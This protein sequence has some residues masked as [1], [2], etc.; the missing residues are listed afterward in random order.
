MRQA[1]EPY[2]A[3]LPRRDLMN[4]SGGRSNISSPP[5]TSLQS[6]IRHPRYR[7]FDPARLIVFVRVNRSN[8]LFGSFGGS[9]TR[10]GS[11]F[12]RFYA[13]EIPMRGISGVLQKVALGS[14][15]ALT[16][17]HSKGTRFFQ[18]HSP[19][20]PVVRRPEAD[21]TAAMFSLVLSD[22]EAEAD[23]GRN[24]ILAQARRIAAQRQFP[25]LDNTDINQSVP[26]S[27]VT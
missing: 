20:L 9:G 8:K 22:N 1:V 10:L 25:V 23:V 21:S 18:K 26:L 11:L 16:R 3:K 13:H 4:V 27:S 17:F 14:K 24:F 5:L 2:M 6:Y 7:C 19:Y 12:G 15:Q